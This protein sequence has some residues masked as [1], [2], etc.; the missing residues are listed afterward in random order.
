MDHHLYHIV[1]IL[2]MVLAAEERAICDGS[3]KQKGHH[4]FFW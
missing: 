2:K 4:W 1:R 3:G